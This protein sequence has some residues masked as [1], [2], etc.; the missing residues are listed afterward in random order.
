MAF[1]RTF[2]VLLALVLTAVPASAARDCVVLVHGLARTSNSMVALDWALR[3]QGYRTV[4]HAYPSTK[5]TLTDLV[6]TLDAPVAQC[7]EAR[8]H[9]VTHS[10]GGILVRAWLAE[11][12]RADV[13]RAVLLAPPNKGSELVDAFGELRLFQWANGPAGGSLGTGSDGTPLRLP[14]PKIEMGVVAGRLSLNPIFSS[15]IPGVDDGKVSVASTHMEGQADHITLPVTH[16]FLMNNPVVI[17]QVVHFLR[18]G[19][20][21]RARSRRVVRE[22][23]FGPSSERATSSR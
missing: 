12:N 15:V 4:R 7:G 8:V 16:T 14:K 19:E 21:D 18:L 17:N 3:R 22:R 6:E 9:F 1:L 2:L 10:M 23:L 11:S 5:H 20:F 13:G